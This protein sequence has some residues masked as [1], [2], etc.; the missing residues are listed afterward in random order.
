MNYNFR[1]YIIL[2]FS[3]TIFNANMLSA[4]E[5]P[6][7]QLRPKIKTIF[8]DPSYGG[9]E[10]GPSLAKKQYSKNL[11]LLLAQELQGILAKAGF[12][13]YLSREADQLVYL[14]ERPFQAKSR[15]ADIYLAISISIRKNDCISL[16]T[17]TQP[18]VIKSTAKT[19]HK[20]VTKLNG[21]LDEIFRNLDMTDKYESSL[22]LAQ[23]MKKEIDSQGIINSVK[24]TRDNNYVL[25]NTEMP[26]VIIDIGL[27]K[28]SA[29][30]PFILDVKKQD[31]I[32]RAVAVSIEAYSDERSASS[33]TKDLRK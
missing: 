21:E 32:V 23:K 13:V 28:Q 19:V 4:E 9:K 30:V 15:G 24:I 2:F 17:V 33:P 14:E 29:H 27:S 1:V 18:K 8:I 26:T 16:L 3:V 25:L 12:E 6:S 31:K 7:K 10:Y 11:T 22:E 20:S 5:S